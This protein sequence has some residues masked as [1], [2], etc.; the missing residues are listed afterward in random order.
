MLTLAALVF[1]AWM[2]PLPQEEDPYQ[3]PFEDEETGVT[4]F[5]QATLDAKMAEILPR[6][7][8]IRGWSFKEPVRAGVQSVE[9]FMIFA[10]QSFEEE[11]GAERYA[12]MMTSAFLLGMVPGEDQMEEIME[13]MLK[14]SV[15]G[16]YDPKTRHFWIMSSF[17]Q[18]PMADLIMA[19]ELQHALDD[20]IYPLEPLLAATL[21]NSDQ[22]FAARCVVEGSATSAMNLYM[23]EAMRNDW[24]PPGDLLSADMITQQLNGIA[25]APVALLASLLL[26]YIE[27]NAFLLRGGSILDGATRAPPEADL[28]RAFTAPPVSSEQVLHPEKYW[29]PEQLDLPRPVIV[30]DRSAALGAGWRSVDEDTLGEIGCALIAVERLPGPIELQFGAM[31]LRNPASAGWGGDRYRTYRHEDGGRILHARLEWDTEADA[32]EFLTALDRPAARARMP[33]LRQHVR[34]G[35]VVELVCADAAGAAAA[36]RLLGAR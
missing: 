7:E 11:Y 16:Y 24:L 3:I 6:L 22:Q 18:G 27:G 1:T 35:A 14:A 8:K 15:G 31:G 25:D 2:T 12:G 29:D 30:P 26:P 36:S 5:D 17:S 4:G 9:E 21:G 32:V 13:K 33:L 10:N 23:V 20:Q 28:V 34:Q 19:H